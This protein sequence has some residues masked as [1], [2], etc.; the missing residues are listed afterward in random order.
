MLRMQWLGSERLIGVLQNMDGNIGREVAASIGVLTLRLQRRVKS[1]NLSGKVLNKRT[2]TLARSI[3][4][5]VEQRGGRIS[6][7]VNT[8]VAYGRAHEYGFSGTVSVRAHLRQMTHVFGNV[9]PEPMTVL[10]RAHNRKMNLPERSFL[11][12]ALREMQPEIAAEIRTA[13]ERGSR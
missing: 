2:G 13:V 8:N 6:G 5:F 11:R 3:D 12:S 1:P 4:Q 9:L 7:V 10:V